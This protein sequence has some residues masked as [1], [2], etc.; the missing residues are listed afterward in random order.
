MKKFTLL[1][2]MALAATAAN[3]QYTVEDA[4]IAPVLEKGVNAAEFYVFQLDP[5]TVENLKKE[6]KTVHDYTLNPEL[7]RNL[8][9]WNGLI[10]GDGSM[11]GVDFQTEGYVSLSVA[12]DAGW[13]GGGFNQSH[14][15]RIG[16]VENPNG[17]CPGMDLSGVNANT[18]LH[19]AF[20][21]SGTASS[22]LGF[23]FMDDD[24]VKDA[25]AH[26]CI[27]PNA[28]ENYPMVAQAITDEWQAIDISFADL[29]KLWPSFNFTPSNDWC[30]NYL[31]FH[32]T[33][34]PGQSFS[35]DAFYLYQAKSEAGV[36]DIESGNFDIVVTGKTANA[37][38]ASSMQIYNMAGQCVKSVNGSTIG[39]DNLPAGVY[40]VKAGNNVRKIAVK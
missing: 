36:A 25:N 4:G 40:V 20:R 17:T 30:G 19:M 10:G 22:S 26:F 1:T 16:G 8:W 39:I 27:G 3:A 2:A 23:T 24:A 6:G 12:P 13:A 38:G 32:P 9:I 21:A 28:Y 29:K 35:L 37:T 11:P 18:R 33:Y 15:A 5:I 31:A 14:D 7:G 34:I